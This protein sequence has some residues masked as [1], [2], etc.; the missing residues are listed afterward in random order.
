MYEKVLPVM[1]CIGEG[2]APPCCEWAIGEGIAWGCPRINI[3][4]GAAPA[5]EIRGEGIG[6]PPECRSCGCG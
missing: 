1:Y 5:A 4:D 3:G 2:G 6:L